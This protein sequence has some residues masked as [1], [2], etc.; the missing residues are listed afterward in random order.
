MCVYM[1]QCE[2]KKD[3]SV[4]EGEQRQEGE[5]TGFVDKILC[6]CVC[7]RTCMCVDVNHLALPPI[8]PPSPLHPPGPRFSAAGSAG[9]THQTPDPLSARSS[10]PE[11]VRQKADEKCVSVRVCVCCCFESRGGGSSSRS[12]AREDAKMKRRSMGENEVPKELH[13]KKSREMNECVFVHRQTGAGRKLELF[14]GE[15]EVKNED[16]EETGGDQIKVRRHDVHRAPAARPCQ[17]AL[18]TFCCH[19]DGLVN[20]RGK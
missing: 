11:T 20:R 16:R 9:D 15:C 7:E 2:E 10:W 19:S 8:P 3:D 4:T 6:A 13:R 14:G 18:H 17:S 5:W 1:L 12:T